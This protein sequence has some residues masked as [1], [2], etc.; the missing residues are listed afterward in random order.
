MR[1]TNRVVVYCDDIPRQLFSAKEL[2]DGTL[3]LSVSGPD[4]L[5]ADSPD[6]PGTMGSINGPYENKVENRF[7]LHSSRMSLTGA[8]LF[9]HTKR[10]LDR[11]ELTAAT[12]WQPGPTG[13][14]ALVYIQNCAAMN[15]PSHIPDIKAS[16]IVTT[17]GVYDPQ[18]AT[19]VYVVL[20]GD[21]GFFQVQVPETS[22][23]NCTITSFPNTDVVVLHT[24]LNA[25]SL[26]RGGIAMTTTSKRI[27]KD[28]TPEVLVEGGSPSINLKNIAIFLDSVQT[29]ARDI[30]M[31]QTVVWL[32]QG[33]VPFTDAQYRELE[34][35]ACTF[36]T[37]P[38]FS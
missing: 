17:L 22:P 19:L 9:K 18:F 10:L 20:A 13:V 31:H 25:P 38:I 30:H 26:P 7:S 32:Q 15:V 6:N 27:Y 29:G 1:K 34:H 3:L 21:P 35:L 2:R 8:R 11:S 24:Y 33:N 23:F 36:S 14:A 37:E 4:Q 28:E 16:D 5:V 12:L